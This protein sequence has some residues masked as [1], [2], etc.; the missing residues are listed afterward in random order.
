MKAEESNLT[1][2]KTTQIIVHGFVRGP[3]SFS[4]KPGYRASDYIAMVGGVLNIGSENNTII[5]RANGS[6]LQ[7]AY[8]EYVEPG[9]VIVVPESFRSRF[10]GNI[11]ILQTATA[12]ATLILTYQAATKG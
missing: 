5:Y 12:I 2:Y 10:F 4:Y 6:E 7:S 8:D 3:R 11:S 9:D 1:E